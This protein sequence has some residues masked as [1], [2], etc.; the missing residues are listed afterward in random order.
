[1]AGITSTLLTGYVI[2]TFTLVCEKAR[3]FHVWMISAFDEVALR[4][5]PTIGKSPTGQVYLLMNTNKPG[6]WAIPIRRSTNY[7]MRSSN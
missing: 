3:T 4:F 6:F 1:M 7:A 5:V 2:S